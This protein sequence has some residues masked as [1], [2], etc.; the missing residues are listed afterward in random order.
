MNFYKFP[1]LASKHSSLERILWLKNFPCG[2][3]KKIFRF[4]YNDL[5]TFFLCAEAL[6][7]AIWN[8][9]KLQKLG[10]GKI[11]SLPV[12]VSRE[13]KNYYF[14]KGS[15]DISIHFDLIVKWRAV[16]SDLH[17][18]TLLDPDPGRVNFKGKIRKNARKLVVILIL[19]LKRK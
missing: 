14:W 1:Y 11:N 19:F 7:L 6:T 2:S 18:F 3:G 5:K 4:L 15:G 17:S 12:F 16:D 13:R 10:K 8:K 9:W